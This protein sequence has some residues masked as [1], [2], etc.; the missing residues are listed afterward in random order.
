MIPFNE[1]LRS[2]RKKKG[3]TQR[4]VASA[5]EITERNYQYYES[6]EREPSM[7]TLIALADYIDVSLDYLVGRSDDPHRY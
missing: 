4:Q 1:H 5:I 6:G 2:I 7:G 3:Y